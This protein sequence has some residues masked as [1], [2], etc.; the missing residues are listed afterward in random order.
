MGLDGGGDFLHGDESGAVH[1]A[2]K[3]APAFLCPGSRGEV[4]QF[5]GLLFHGPGPG[6]LERN[7]RQGH[8]PN[9]AAI[10]RSF[11]IPQP[12]M[13]GARENAVFSE[14]AVFFNA[15]A[16][17]GLTEIP[18]DVETVEA[19]FPFCSR[20]LLQKGVDKCFPHIHGYCLDSLRLF[21]AQCVEP[22]APS[23]FSPWSVRP[24]PSPL[25]SL[26]GSLAGRWSRPH[27]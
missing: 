20:Q 7:F 23:R 26:A 10:I 11:G 16:I 14:C 18:D 6:S 17:N 4:P 1:P 15:N 21:F 3:M 12:V 27:S 24:R 13:F 2:Q 22:G 5:P 19:D 8:E 25:S 9:S